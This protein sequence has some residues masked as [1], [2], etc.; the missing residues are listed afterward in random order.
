M[1]IPDEIPNGE[2][3]S[4]GAPDDKGAVFGAPLAP[5]ADGKPPEG[6]VDDLSP[7]ILGGAKE[8]QA[9]PNLAYSL[10]GVAAAAGAESGS[11]MTADAADDSPPSDDASAVDVS[12]YAAS[13]I[14][15]AKSFLERHGVSIDYSGETWLEA[16]VPARLLGALS[17]RTDVIRV[18]TIVRAVPDQAPSPSPTPEP[19]RDERG[20]LTV[21]GL[22][23]EEAVS[24]TWTSACQ[25]ATTSP[26]ATSGSRYARFYTFT[27]SAR[28]VGRSPSAGRRNAQLD[29]AADR[30]R[31]PLAF[32]L[33]FGELLKV[34]VKQLFLFRLRH[35]IAR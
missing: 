25:S 22:A 9:F 10:D 30:F 12:V 13:D 29:L 27:L 24:G 17:E 19:R 8:A 7:D 2:G 20:T 4:G 26:D 23:R 11:L 34:V 14:S 28:A 21:S 16:S 6:E 32:A 3:A 31:Q 15:D 33:G 18:E 35:L 5:S 1:A